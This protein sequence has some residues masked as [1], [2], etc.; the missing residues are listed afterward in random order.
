[1][2]SFVRSSIGFS[3][4]KMKPEFGLEPPE[5]EKPMTEKVPQ[6][7]LVLADHRRGLVGNI[8]RVRSEAPGGVC[9]MHRK[10][11]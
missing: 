3:G 2:P 6:H 8:G 9:T 11:P 5:S 10:Y 1:M 7:I 4:A